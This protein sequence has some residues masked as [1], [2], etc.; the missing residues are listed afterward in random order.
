MKY[1][2]T[3]SHL[4]F[5]GRH[6]E[7]P[8]VFFLSGWMITQP[9]FSLA[10]PEKKRILDIKFYEFMFFILLYKFDIMF[11]NPIILTL[12]TEEDRLLIPQFQLHHP[13]VNSV[14]TK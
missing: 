9:R 2:T 11:L 14:V 1:V 3:L 12:P 6:C 8:K 10:L 7:H 5:I 13:A 4:K